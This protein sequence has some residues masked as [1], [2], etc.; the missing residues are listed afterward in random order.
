MTAINWGEK[1]GE[2]GGGRRI[3]VVVDVCFVL[4]FVVV[5]VV[6][7]VGYCLFVLFCF[8]LGLAFCSL[9]QPCGRAQWTQKSRS[10]FAENPELLQRVYTVQASSTTIILLIF[11]LNPVPEVSAVLI[12]IFSVHSTSFFPHSLFKNIIKVLWV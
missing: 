7:G 9:H 6:F 2:G 11:V 5:V 8:F 3:F 1:R 10:P 12:S 4:V